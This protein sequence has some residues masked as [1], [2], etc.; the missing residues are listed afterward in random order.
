MY[1]CG[2]CQHI[3]EPG[4]ICPPP[5]YI[6]ARDKLIEQA[7]K[8]NVTEIDEPTLRSVRR[9]KLSAN[10]QAWLKTILSTEK[11][12]VVYDG[13]DECFYFQRRDGK[14]LDTFEVDGTEDFFGR[15]QV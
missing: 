4:H 8:A 9:I 6:D 13:R 2:R 10:V 1:V 12:I 15:R 11:I 7:A 3:M 5:E 14:L